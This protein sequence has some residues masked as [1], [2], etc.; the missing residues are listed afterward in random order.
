[1]SF[2][3]FCWL[4]VALVP[5]YLGL[6]ALLPPFDDELYYWCWSRELQLSYYD[7]PP[8]VAYMIRGAT[9]LFGDG[10]VAMR[11]PAVLSAVVVAGVIGWLSRPRDLLPL[12]VLS[13][14][15]TFAAVMVTPDT[16]LLMFWA[17]YL[18]WLVAVHERLGPGRDEPGRSPGIALWL[19]GGVLLGC[20][21]LGKYTMGL[22]A[23]AGGVSFLLAGNPRRWL[24]G[25]A[26]HALVA[27]AVASPILIHNLRHDFT[28][29]RY[30]WGHSM[31][32]PAPGLG[33]FAE[34]VGVQMLLVGTVP[35]VVFAWALGRRRELLADPRLRVCLCLFA[36]PFAFFLWKATQGRI[37]GNWAFPCYLACWPLAAEWY[38]RVR[39]S[40]RWRWATRAGFALPL[41][42]SAFFLV[43]LVEPVGAFP[44]RADRATRQHERMTVARELAADL[45]DAGHAGPVY[46]PTYQW[47]A[48]LR[49]HGIDARQIAGMS[50]PSHFTEHGGQAID[51]DRALVFTEAPARPDKF[52]GFGAPRSAA[53]YPVVVRGVPHE[54]CWLLDYSGNVGRAGRGSAIAGRGRLDPTPHHPRR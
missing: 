26:V 30:Q 25:Y 40:A 9:E 37:E 51:R 3:G 54:P 44:P 5:V 45:R 43:H 24:V 22:A 7:H 42:A 21:V 53:C 28:P 47:T 19:L 32:S 41:G 15:L 35:L 16:P 39:G 27:V 36:L 38:A 20:G 48:I 31:G 11:L 23:L 1:V 17:L 6:A 29:I 33:P 34:F 52:P 8:M 50:R 2:R 4:L 18:A 10:I 14:V 46:V 13:P 49:W 12:I